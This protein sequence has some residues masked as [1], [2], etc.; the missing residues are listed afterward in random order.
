MTT[1][2]SL[3]IDILSKAA[4]VDLIPGVDVRAEQLPGVEERFEISILGSELVV[5]LEGGCLCRGQNLRRVGLEL[6]FAASDQL[7]ERRII[8]GV[9]ARQHGHVRLKG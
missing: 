3:P 4:L 6:N 5:D 8:L 9:V 7:L 1:L 2:A